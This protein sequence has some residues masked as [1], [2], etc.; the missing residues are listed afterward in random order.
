M[1]VKGRPDGSPFLVT[2]NLD[3]STI[4]AMKGKKG[5]D[6][7]KDVGES[8]DNA[9]RLKFDEE[10]III[11]QKGGAATKVHKRDLKNSAVINPTKYQWKLLPP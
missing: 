5:S 4:P 3:L 6:L 10:R 2:R 7:R 9:V 1:D 8:K 11:V